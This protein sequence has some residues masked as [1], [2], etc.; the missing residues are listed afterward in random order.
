M[1]CKAQVYNDGSWVCWQC[2]IGG[3]QGEDPADFCPKQRRL[4]D[5]LA[6]AAKVA[7]KNSKPAKR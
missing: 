6:E 3:D 1:D 7:E 5:D 2:D 4:T